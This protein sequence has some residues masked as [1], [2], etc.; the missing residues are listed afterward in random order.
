M[1]HVCSNVLKGI[2]RLNFR[3]SEVAAPKSAATFELIFS[4]ILYY[5]TSAPY[6]SV[7]N[8]TENSAFSQYQGQL[9]LQKQFSSLS[10]H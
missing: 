3:N 7:I 4:D 8:Q 10:H 6:L 5:K 1:R 9:P 2:F